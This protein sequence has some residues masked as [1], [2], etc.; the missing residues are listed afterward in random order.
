M[1]KALHLPKG[2]GDWELLTRV[3]GAEEAAQ[4][5]T[6]S[7]RTKLL[8][9]RRLVASGAAA[10]PIARKVRDEMYVVMDGYA[11]FGARGVEPE[12]TLVDVIEHGLGLEAWTL[13]RK[14]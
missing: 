3:A 5:M 1:K 13:P 6:E 10:L 11:A 14:D 12:T 9:A 2:A 7:L 4:K 8:E